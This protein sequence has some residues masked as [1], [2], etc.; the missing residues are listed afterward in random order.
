MNKFNKFLLVLILAFIQLNSKAQQNDSLSS[1]LKMAATNNP[2]LHS[3]FLKYSAS[4]E[5]I[6]PAGS[7]PD[8]QLEFGYFLK[9]MELLSGKQIAEFKLMQMFP[10]FGSLP[11]AQEEASKM[12]ASNFESFL[13]YRNELIFNVKS[14]YYILFKNKKEIDITENNLQLLKSMEQLILSKYQSNQGKGISNAKESSDDAS[15]SSSPSSTMGSMGALSTSNPTNKSTSSNFSGSSMSSGSENQMIN[16]FRIKMEINTMENSLTFL[17]D[18]FKTNQISFNRYLN[19]SPEHIIFI[20]DSLIEE[21]VPIKFTALIDSI[22]NNPM[23]KMYQADSAAYNAKIMMSK[24]M[25]YPMVGIGLK[26]SLINKVDNSTNMMNGQ[27]ML[28][29]MV[30]ASLPIHRKKYQSII[31]EAD[32]LRS[33]ASYAS[34]NATNDLRVSYQQSLQNL[35]DAQ[36]RSILYSKQ[37]LLAEGSLNILLASFSSN[38]SG[39]DEIILMEQQLL[40]YKFKKIEAT[41]DKYAS[42]ANLL[43]LLGK[44]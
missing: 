10:W 23:V 35:E 3:M 18:Q 26:Y 8:P 40:N 44:Q 11:A 33:A 38:S 22:T 36:R 30:T 16:L 6:T 43:F 14:N 21:E 28:M 9:P 7:L 31:K 37:T 19:Q 27:D 13:A 24:K 1:Y 20:P 34:V 5:K 12:A 32:L 29:P 2:G 17:L 41:T 15:K 25:S 39:L 42:T 4:L